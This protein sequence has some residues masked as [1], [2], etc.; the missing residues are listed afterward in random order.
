MRVQ[1]SS[2]ISIVGNWTVS[3]VQKL[4]RNIVRIPRDLRTA[5]IISS[6]TVQ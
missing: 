1:I 2:A 3:G 4:H 5:S 6:E